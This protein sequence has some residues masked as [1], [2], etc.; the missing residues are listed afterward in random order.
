MKMLTAIN[1]ALAAFPQR[2]R[3][4]ALAQFIIRYTCPN[5]SVTHYRCIG[6]DAD[7]IVKFLE[8]LGLTKDD[9]TVV[10]SEL[11][12]ETRQIRWNKTSKLVGQFM[13]VLA[14][15][16]SSP[17][18]YNSITNGDPAKVFADKDDGEGQANL[19]IDH[20]MYKVQNKSD[21]IMKWIVEGSYTNEA[22]S[23]LFCENTSFSV[24]NLFT[25]FNRPH[26][27]PVPALEQYAWG[28]QILPP[29]VEKP[30]RPLF[31]PGYCGNLTACRYMDPTDTLKFT[32]GIYEMP[33]P[34]LLHPS[35]TPSGEPNPLQG[36]LATTMSDAISNIGV[37]PNSEYLYAL[38]SGCFV[39]D[40]YTEAKLKENLETMEF[41]ANPKKFWRYVASLYSTVYGLNCS[42]APGSRVV[43]CNEWYTLF[44]PGACKEYYVSGRSPN[45]FC[46]GDDNESDRPMGMCA[47]VILTPVQASIAPLQDSLDDNATV[48]VADAVGSPS[49][50]C[51][52][53]HILN[54]P[55][56]ADLPSMWFA[57]THVD[58][59]TIIPGRLDVVTGQRGSHLV[60]P[61]LQ[62]QSNTMTIF[63]EIAAQ[64]KGK[65]LAKLTQC[66]ATL[67]PECACHSAF[68]TGVAGVILSCLP[69]GSGSD[70]VTWGGTS[71]ECHNKDLFVPNIYSGITTD[72]SPTLSDGTCPEHFPTLTVVPSKEQ[73]TEFIDNLAQGNCDAQ[74]SMAKRTKGT[75]RYANVIVETNFNYSHLLDVWTSSGG[76]VLRNKLR[77]AFIQ[78]FVLRNRQIAAAVSP[79]Y[80]IHRFCYHS[81]LDEVYKINTGASVYDDMVIPDTTS[82][83]YMLGYDLTLL[84]DVYGRAYIVYRVEAS[85]AAY[86]MAAYRFQVGM[87]VFTKHTAIRGLI[88]TQNRLTPEEATRPSS[89][90][91]QKFIKFVIAEKLRRAS[92]ATSACLDLQMDTLTRLSC[93]TPAFSRDFVSWRLSYCEHAV[94]KNILTGP[95]DLD[96]LPTSH[97]FSVG[98][99]FT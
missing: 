22:F 50:E 6:Q 9:F 85:Y 98:F 26:I 37:K 29:D 53:D 52:P 90:T 13:S 70:V 30:P 94:H 15:V 45:P 42:I 56:K 86:A 36:F 3:R 93:W 20:F 12:P 41:I 64:W 84:S 79:N 59:D 83:N 8:T 74:L 21:E 51:L 57:A 61:V 87:P 5:T 96:T 23:S 24:E 31:I 66:E 35:E 27:L 78:A 55:D 54:A 48:T 32:T 80:A 72:L 4:I 10:R 81:T 40:D 7:V 92:V 91:C 75:S 89:T 69:P 2:E 63:R 38:T 99:W 44:P 71:I 88:S 11:D 95:C 28:T 43:V 49:E 62:T 25:D 39:T 19:S 58:P 97:D 33:A 1:T 16:A 46:S 67:A 47:G 68:A 65:T 60:C 73:F 76:L 18:A 34:Y 14:S 82:D 17:E 77:K